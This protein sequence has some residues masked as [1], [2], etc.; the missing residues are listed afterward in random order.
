[1]TR[2][3]KLYALLLM[4]PFVLV[5][6][7]I[8]YLA[9]QDANISIRDVRI[10]N[11]TDS[12]A[13]ITWISDNAYQGAVIYQESDNWPVVFAQLGKKFYEDDRDNEELIKQTPV[14]ELG[15]PANNYRNTHHVTISGLRADSTYYF[16]I[17]GVINGKAAE[18]KSFTTGQIPEDIKTPDPAYGQVESN[19]IN[20]DDSILTL[21]AGPGGR[22]ISTVMNN[23]GRYTVDFNS[24][25]AS[26][27]KPESLELLINSGA[28][29]AEKY[30]Y[31]N[32]ADYKPLEKII[33]VQSDAP[34]A[35][36]AAHNVLGAVSASDNNAMSSLAASICGQEI[37]KTLSL[38]TIDQL[39]LR[40]F[41]GLTGAIV[42]SFAKD[43]SLYVLA[44]TEA[45]PRTVDC[46]NED[47]Y[48]WIQV[49]T[50]PEGQSAQ[51]GW[52]AVNFLTQNPQSETNNNDNSSARGHSEG[53]RINFC[54]SFEGEG[55]YYMT[56]KAGQTTYTYKSPPIIE[57]F[58]GSD[59]DYEVGLN[60]ADAYGVAGLPY[61][62]SPGRI[63]KVADCTVL[64]GD[65]INE[66]QWL[67]VQ[68]LDDINSGWAS[69][70]Q[71]VVM[72]EA[73]PDAIDYENETLAIESRFRKG[74]REFIQERPSLSRLFDSQDFTY[75][76]EPLL[77]SCVDPGYR[78]KQSE[79]ISVSYDSQARV[80]NPFFTT[81]LEFM[82]D[83]YT[84]PES[85]R[86]TNTLC[87]NSNMWVMQCN[88]S[89]SITESDAGRQGECGEPS[90]LNQVRPDLRF[91]TGID[92]DQ[93]E[94]RLTDLE[95][96][97]EH[98]DIR[99]CGDQLNSILSKM[100]TTDLTN[101]IWLFD[102]T[103]KL[104]AIAG[105]VNGMTIIN[106]LYYD[107][108]SRRLESIERYR[109]GLLRHMGVETGR[110]GTYR[111]EN[112]CIYLRETNNGVISFLIQDAFL[113]NQV[114]RQLNLGLINRCVTN[115]EYDASYIE[116][117]DSLT[118]ED[119]YVFALRFGTFSNTCW[120]HPK[121]DNTQNENT[122]LV[123]IAVV[124]Q[125]VRLDNTRYQEIAINNQARGLDE[126]AYFKSY[127]NNSCTGR[128][129]KLNESMYW[130][131]CVRA[132]TEGTLSLLEARRLIGYSILDQYANDGPGVRR[133]QTGPG[134]PSERD[135]YHIFQTLDGCKNWQKDSIGNKKYRKP[136][137]PSVVM[138]GPPGSGSMIP[139]GLSSIGQKSLTPMS[140]APKVLG[141]SQAQQPAQPLE[142]TESGRYSFFENG[143]KIAE[144]DVIVSDEKVEI[145][146]FVDSN[147][148]GIKDAGEEYYAGERQVNLTKEA[149]LEEFSLNSG[150]N[151]I[152]LPLIDAR[153]EGAVNS[154]AKLVDYWNEQGADVRHVARFI[155]GQ[156]QI[157]S[158]RETGTQYTQDFELVPGEG[159]FV[160]NR[161]ENVNVSFSGKRYDGSLPLKL[162]NGWNLVGIINGGL[163]VNS[164][165]LLKKTEGQG[166]N[167]DTISQFESASYQSVI[168]KDGLLFGNNFKIVDKRG[169]FI[170]VDSGSA[171]EFDPGK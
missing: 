119:F 98:I 93:P 128:G 37:T 27:Q 50:H 52:A 82:A 59:T 64:Q 80:N 76:M 129:V 140:I 108:D 18:I 53:E 127:A 43:T 31:K 113:P 96:I 2:N 29:L 110:I 154:A 15:T 10:T 55:P 65:S 94:E 102:Q 135:Y 91:I 160:L 101:N 138:C 156:F 6:L 106:P 122:S 60:K 30:Q 103:R 13:T 104:G 25:T 11:L 155:G 152:H 45:L 7:L 123:G 70:G 88:F 111:L 4:I 63:V 126:L 131:E 121:Q 8:G 49:S 161:A 89:Y 38:K 149:N 28:K 19:V 148:N 163:D 12:S 16:R 136:E 32:L 35:D 9:V 40:R 146:L 72:G 47:G 81:V 57:G 24:L 139:G 84:G 134:L 74:F 3:Q 36:A 100:N 116:I 166:I 114:L 105:N 86:F 62:I 58:L 68:S 85:I 169:Y 118:I 23:S 133:D 66:K 97:K 164:E 54:E 117:N 165:E 79:I 142:V 120:L 157:Y 168:R 42:N 33:L 171:K 159:I 21:N 112:S 92:T 26:G 115:R 107:R 132:G 48:S 69:Y 39:N 147:G 83:N 73:D 20:Y 124:D 51:S 90:D 14:L 17:A 78:V 143:E 71:L 61:T 41:P 77:Q 125:I 87:R 44:G 151:L 109:E 99:P 56:T 170:K 75:P 34:I 130:G 46:V 5:T 153:G 162:Q 67:K 141:Q 145:R 1:M 137:T 158:Q 95:F 144:Q 167:A 150:W 22:P